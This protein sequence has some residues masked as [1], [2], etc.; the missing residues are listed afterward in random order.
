MR[1]ELMVNTTP[2]SASNGHEPAAQED[3]QTRLRQPAAD[4][5]R[6]RCFPAHIPPTATSVLPTT[7]TSRT[8]SFSTPTAP[9]A[10]PPINIQPPFLTG[11][12]ATPLNNWQPAQQYQ[13]NQRQGQVQTNRWSCPMQDHTNHHIAEC[14]EFWSLNPRDR[15]IA[16]KFSA[17]Y[18][19]LERNRTCRGGVCT[20]YH[21]VPA[22]LVCP[23][24][25]QMAPPGKAPVC[26]A[27]CGMMGHKKPQLQ[28]LMRA[29]EAWIPHLNFATLGAQVQ[30]NLTT[31]GFH[32]T[33]VMTPPPSSKTGPPTPNLSNMVY[34]TITGDPR[35]LTHKDHVNRT[36]MEVAFYAMQTVRIR[37]QD[38]L[39]FYDSGS[40]CA[41]DRGNS[42]GAAEA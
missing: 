20:N 4:R 13:N 1:H 38:V 9:K 21:E 26:I 27:F 32:S 3:E 23:D 28:E 37:N 39:M 6:H 16:C 31:L 15:R 22:D 10:S 42:G 41:P 19:C 8:R 17:C 2:I 25:A 11:G 24:C 35:P 40:N 7:P 30:V 29:F 5:Q 18:T 36:S 34:D 12:N 14:A 33:S